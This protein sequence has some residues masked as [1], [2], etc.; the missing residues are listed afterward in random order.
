MRGDV[1][2]SGLVMVLIFLLTMASGFLAKE[3]SEKIGL[4]W[5][6]AT[7]EGS[8]GSDSLVATI[9]SIKNSKPTE[10]LGYQ[11]AHTFLY[12]PSTQV[13]LPD[14]LATLGFLTSRS[15][16][17]KEGCMTSACIPYYVE[18][19]GN[20]CEIDL[21]EGEVYKVKIWKCGHSICVCPLNEV[22]NE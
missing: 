10:Y 16:D 12:K 18:E 1:I 17:E 20:L 13:Y 14:V 22:E 11:N 3:V 8:Q 5:A 9:L 15:E 4:S 19:P 7:I 6:K 21:E 2:I